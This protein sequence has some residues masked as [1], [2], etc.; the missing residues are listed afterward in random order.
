MNPSSFNRRNFLRSTVL[1]TSGLI[2]GSTAL[3]ANANG[4]TH[5]KKKSKM[6]YRT[7][8]RTG[9]QLPVVSMGVMRADNPN[10]VKA[11][12]DQG[13]KLLDTANGYQH[14]RNEEMLGKVLKDYPRKSYYLATKVHLEGM[15]RKTGMYNEKA[16]K[17][18]FLSK[19]NVSMKRLNIGYV[20][21]LY[22]HAVSS[23]EATLHKP[24]LAA[25]KEIKDSGK[26]K[27]VG[28]STHQNI[29]EV[30]QAAIDSKFYEVILVAYN[31]KQKNRDDIK[32]AI[33]NAAEAGLGVV[34]MKTMAGGFLDK[35]R[36][37]PVNTKAALK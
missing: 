5:K 21:I 1:G 17:E 13:V 29:P 26:A 14:G 18:D 36:T 16:T 3:Q 30:I 8:G 11:A 32:L 27:F 37:K 28:I 20:D 25:M 10:L 31:S 6:V 24:A 12:L 19:F 15:D 34:V 23:R 4:T 33:A 22:H 9:M 35:D 7:L 2:M